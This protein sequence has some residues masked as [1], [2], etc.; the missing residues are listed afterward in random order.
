[1]EVATAFA[2]AVVRKRWP[3]IIPL[4]STSAKSKYTA[5]SLAAEFGWKQLGARLRREFIEASGE[6]EDM[7]PK[8]DPPKRFETFEVEDRDPPPGHDPKVP[9]VWIEVDF[10][11]SEDSEFDVCYNCFL[12]FVDE[13]EPRIE[14]YSIESAME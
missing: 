13:G 1:M 8:L 9:I 6:S 12:A 2:T 14:A 4:L 10:Q 3:E 11:P 5:D 7:V